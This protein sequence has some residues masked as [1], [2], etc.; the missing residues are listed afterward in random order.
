MH[1]FREM[2]AAFDKIAAEVVAGTRAA[3]DEAAHL[4]QKQAQTNASGRPGPMVRSGALRRSIVVIGPEAAGPGTFVAHVGPTVVYGRAIEE[5]H[6]RWKSGVKY[7]Y[8]GPA[9]DF[10]T[11]IALPVIFERH[12][13]AALLV[14]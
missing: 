4:L 11:R 10:V 2:Q 6:P 14:G 7:P 8:L 13:G 3:V 1:G 12:W 9:H 5:G